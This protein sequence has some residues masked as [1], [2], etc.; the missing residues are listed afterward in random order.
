MST[1]RHRM[2]IAGLT[3][4]FFMNLTGW[5]ESYVRKLIT[6]KIKADKAQRVIKDLLEKVEALKP[7]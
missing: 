1:I 6:G 7:K 3:Y 4:R 5:S 2:K